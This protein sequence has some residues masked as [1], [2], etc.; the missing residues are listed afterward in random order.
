MLLGIPH[1]VE[2]TVGLARRACVY[3]VVFEA[4]PLQKLQCI[5]A[6]KL[7]AIVRLLLDVD[8]MHVK[9]RPLVAG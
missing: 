8:A 2:A 9:S 4:K 3:G 7:S 1:L 5:A 6:R